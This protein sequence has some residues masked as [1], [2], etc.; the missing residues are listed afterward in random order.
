MASTYE[1]WKSRYLLTMLAVELMCNMLAL[2]S[3]EKMFLFFFFSYQSRPRSA[4]KR[5]L[6]PDI[7]GFDLRDFALRLQSIFFFFKAPVETFI[8]A[9][10]LSVSFASPAIQ[11][12]FA[13]VTGGG[14]SVI[15]L[16]T[17]GGVQ[18]R[19]VHQQTEG[20]SGAPHMRRTA[21]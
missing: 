3:L 11:Q 6:G 5:G 2:A 1:R 15:A 9:S 13:L 10:R 14:G 4:L 8:V 19:Y 12:V 7:V 18:R 21:G 20:R 17:R 16:V